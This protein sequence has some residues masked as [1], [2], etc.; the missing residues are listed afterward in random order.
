MVELWRVDIC[1]EV[2]MMSSHLALPSQGHIE[3]VLHMFCYL[4]KYHNGTLVY[5]P[6]D[7]GINE[8]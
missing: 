7:P 1:L 3:Q 8:E 2:S 4:K 5:D 6:S